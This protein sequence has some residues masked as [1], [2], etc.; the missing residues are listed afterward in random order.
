MLGRLLRIV[1]GYVVGC[2]AA[3]LTQVLFVYTPAHLA[4]LSPEAASDQLA[5]ALGYALPVGVVAAMF[6]FP[7]ALIGILYGEWRRV[8]SWTY[9][10]LLGIAIALLGFLAQYNSEAGTGDSVLQQYPLTA[11]LWTGFAG[12]FVYWLFSGRSAG[13]RTAEPQVRT[14]GHVKGGEEKA[15]ATNGPKSPPKPQLAVA[16]TKP[17]GPAAGVKPAGSKG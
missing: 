9:Y 4:A 3:G 1:F 2:L 11:F 13:P 17:T 14:S 10:A 16:P 12:G 8:R 5:E 15:A 7:F 6:A